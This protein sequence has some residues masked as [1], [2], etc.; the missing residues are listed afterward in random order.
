M[1]AKYNGDGAKFYSWL[2]IGVIQFLT[3]N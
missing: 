3:K 2:Q 1:R